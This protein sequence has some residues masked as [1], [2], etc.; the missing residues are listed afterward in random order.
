MKMNK[1]RNIKKQPMVIKRSNVSTF[2]S[3]HQGG[4]VKGGCYLVRGQRVNDD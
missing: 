1:I 4:T 3:H 2:L